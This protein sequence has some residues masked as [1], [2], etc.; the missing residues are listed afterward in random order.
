MLRGDLETV[1]GEEHRVRALK[2]AYYFFFLRC[3][4]P[5]YFIYQ[6]RYPP[7][8]HPFI[9]PL[10]SDKS[11]ISG[12]LDLATGIVKY[13]RNPCNTRPEWVK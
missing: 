9:K 4:D 2:Y 1:I 6:N 11:K 10:V 8:R 12:M 13:V 5:G 3:F 7:F